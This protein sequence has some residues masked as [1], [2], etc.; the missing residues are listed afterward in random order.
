MLTVAMAFESISDDYDI[1]PLKDMLADARDVHT[2]VDQTFT[3]IEIEGHPLRIAYAYA[4]LRVAHKHFKGIVTLVQDRNYISAL[5]LMRPLIESSFRG[6][7]LCT[8]AGKHIDETVLQQERPIKYPA[9]KLMISDVTAALSQQEFFGQF[10]EL[11]STM[12][13][14]AHTGPLLLK[15]Y[16]SDLLTPDKQILTVGDVLILLSA[17]V[18]LS[19]DAYS[20]LA[21][22]G[23]VAA[24]VQP[25]LVA[26]KEK[27]ETHQR[28]LGRLSWFSYYLDESEQNNYEWWDPCR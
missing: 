7:W 14:F 24:I 9:F 27:V 8:D 22:N 4:L 23:K 12:C 1:E 21:K 16:A 5:A 3:A 28:T 18:L 10:Q 15:H 26:F 6:L 25:V 20:A 17:H 19:A 11:W 2:V 13:D